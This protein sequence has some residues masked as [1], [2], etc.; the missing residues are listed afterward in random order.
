MS[1]SAIMGCGGGVYH[2]V[3]GVLVVLFRLALHP[4]EPVPAVTA[5]CGKSSAMQ[6][7]CGDSAVRH[8]AVRGRV[9]GLS[10]ASSQ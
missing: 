7:Q 5:Q 1:G 8:S 4:A 6:R 9:R 3:G 10:V 2:V